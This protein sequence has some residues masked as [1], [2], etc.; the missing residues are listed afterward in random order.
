MIPEMK[1]RELCPGGEYLHLAEVK[2]TAAA[3]AE[4]HTHDFYE[5]FLVQGG[6]GR[7]VTAESEQM[8]NR[9][10]LHFVHPKDVHGFWGSASDP[11]TFTNIAIEA[12]VVQRALPQSSTLQ[13]NWEL[14][15]R[16]R[17]VML[18]EKQIREFNL[19]SEDLIV[20]PKAV[21]DADY[22]LLALARLLRP[23]LGVVTH[24]ALPEWLERGLNRALEPVNLQGGVARLVSLCG[25]S[26]EHVSRSFKLHIGMTPSQWVME[27]RINLARRWLET[28]QRSVLDIALECGFE[29]TSY[30][31]ETFKAATGQTPLK[32][33]RR[34]VQVQ[35]PPRT[36][37]LEGHQLG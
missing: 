14:G 31:H 37:G 35:S 18:T 16:I 13:N 21:L 32:Y 3:P 4:L 1:W 25:R 29:S 11:I 30:F 10:E 27:Q 34:V 8:L 23:V 24:A 20:G 17:P 9:G 33:R 7:Q 6:R 5:C 19:L 36:S 26:P 28:T 12:S 15:Q 22:F 2:L